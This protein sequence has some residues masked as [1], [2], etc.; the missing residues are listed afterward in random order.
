[1]RFCTLRGNSRWPPKV[2]GKRFLPKVASTLCRYPM[3]PNFVEIALSRTV[4][5]INALLRFRQKFKIA[6]KSGGKAIYAKKLPVHYSYT[7]LVQNYVEIALSRTVLE[8]NAL[9]RFTK[10][11]K[12]AAKSG[13]KVIFVKSRQYLGVRK[14]STKSFY[15]ARLWR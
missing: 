9:L 5:K 15:L 8:I 14:I 10:K 1:M 4:F 11:F 6:A 13:R 12:M 7:L 2:A 3:G